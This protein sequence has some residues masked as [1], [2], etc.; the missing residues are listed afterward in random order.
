MIDNTLLTIPDLGQLESGLQPVSQKPRE[1]EDDSE[2]ESSNVKNLPPAWKR[3]AIVLSFGAASVYF[4]TLPSQAMTS[5]FFTL[6][7]LKLSKSYMIG[8]PRVR[9]YLT[10]GALAGGAFFL[11]T[12]WDAVNL[13]PLA[14]GL[15]ID[16]LSFTA[17]A[18]MKGKLKKDAGPEETNP[19]LLCFQNAVT[20]SCNTIG[21]CIDFCV[22]RTTSKIASCFTYLTSLCKSQNPQ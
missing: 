7:F 22:D 3:H 14:A 16:G 17:K 15:G 5:L 18:Y 1:D 12:V 8:F 21:G 6:G 13:T 19:A 4:S 10:L 9:R 2:D 20:T 11:K